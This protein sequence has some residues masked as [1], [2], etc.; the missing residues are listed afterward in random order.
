MNVFRRVYKFYAE[1][2]KSMS[3]GRTLWI[4]VG[5]KLFILFAVLRLFFFKPELSKYKSEREKAQHVIECLA[6]EDAEAPENEEGALNGESA[7][8]D[9]RI[10]EENE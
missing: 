10:A 9:E 6:I 2:I 7:K 4:I 1:G 5:I 3:V 8:I